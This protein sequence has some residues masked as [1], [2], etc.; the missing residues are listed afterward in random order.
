MPQL[1]EVGKSSEIIQSII[2]VDGEVLYSP[3][4][5]FENP[6]LI[7]DILEAHGS[8]RIADDLAAVRKHQ[9]LPLD[10]GKYPALADAV[11]RGLAIAP[12]VQRPDGVE[13][14]F[15]TV[16]YIADK[17]IFT[18]RK[19]VLD[20]ALA[21][22]SCVRCGQ[23]FGGA[24]NTSS[25]VAV[26]NKLMDPDRNYTLGAHSSHRRQYQTLFRKQIVT[27]IP[28]GNW[29]QPRLIATEDNLEAVKLARDLLVYGEPVEY[30]GGD[31]TLA[32]L[33]STSLYSAPIQTVKQRRKT[34]PLSDREY[35]DVLSAAMGWSPL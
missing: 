15:V 32:G 8:G 29:V 35:Q 2:T 13:Q 21:I 12:S 33:T 6:Q 24:T 16:P 7:G 4:F 10:T 9:G 18:V 3:F 26:L 11:S 19:E 22:L 28:S 23:H 17:E 5:G 20:K 27:F 30:R 14:P 1:V 31:G 34:R 25:P